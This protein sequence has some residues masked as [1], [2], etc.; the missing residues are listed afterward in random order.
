MCALLLISIIVAPQTWTDRVAD[1][2]R[3]RIGSQGNVEVSSHGSG[4]GVVGS[5]DT[6]TKAREFHHLVMQAVEAIEEEL[7]QERLGAGL[8]RLQI[9]AH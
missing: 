8:P 7:S 1:A 5:G 3:V 9:R 2:L 6:P 4:I